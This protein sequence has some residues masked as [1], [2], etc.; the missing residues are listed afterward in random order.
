MYCYYH[1]YYSGFAPSALGFRWQMTSGSLLAHWGIWIHPQQAGGA[2]SPQDSWPHQWSGDLGASY[3]HKSMVALR[4][5]SSPG[6]LWSNTCICKANVAQQ[7]LE[8]FPKGGT[9]H[10][11]TSGGL[12]L[13]SLHKNLKTFWS[14]GKS[15]SWWN[16]PLMSLLMAMGCSLN[17]R[18]P[19][20]LAF[21]VGPGRWPS[22]W[23]SNWRRS[24][25]FHYDITIWLYGDGYTI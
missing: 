24:C 18:T 23:R 6:L 10:W 19:S 22:V 11:W 8:I 16:M 7:G 25:P 13:M 21:K 5:T 4:L 17:G 14:L 9:F 15:L 12:D 20:K 2:S 3:Q 1:Y